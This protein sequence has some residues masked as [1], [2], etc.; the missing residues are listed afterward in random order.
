MDKLSSKLSH[1]HPTSM[2]STSANI[3]RSSLGSWWFWYTAAMAG[4][5]ASGA[6]AGARVGDRLGRLR[7]PR[8]PPSRKLSSKRRLKSCRL[9]QFR[10]GP[11][12]PWP[13]YLYQKHLLM[14]SASSGS[15]CGRWAWAS[16]PDK[17]RTSWDASKQPFMGSLWDVVSFQLI[18]KQAK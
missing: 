8:P 10:T 2:F 15:N 7:G 16:R 4:S 6:G 1:I 14:S 17:L 12:A 11:Q 5:A 9:W 18:L 3:L 13:I